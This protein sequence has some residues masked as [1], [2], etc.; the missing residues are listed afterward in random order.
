MDDNFVKRALME[1][2]LLYSTRTRAAEKRIEREHPG[3]VGSS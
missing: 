1:G 2:W 3:G